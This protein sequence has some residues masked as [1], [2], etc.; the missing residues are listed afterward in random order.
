VFVFAVYLT[1][2]SVTQR[3]QC[4]MAGKVKLSPCTTPYRRTEEWCIDPHFLDLGTSWRWVVSFTP[5]PLYP[6]GKSPRYPLD[7]RLGREE[8]IPDP[9]GTRT[10]TPRPSS[11]VFCVIPCSPPKRELTFNGLYGVISQKIELFITTAERTTN[12]SRNYEL[13]CRQVRSNLG[14]WHMVYFNLLSLHYRG[15]I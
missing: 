3:I 14:T 10:P 1:R 5:R 8:K 6:Y 12:F 15:L 11:S 13:G 4:R 9:T 7:R 2:S